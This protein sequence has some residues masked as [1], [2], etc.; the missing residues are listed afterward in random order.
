MRKSDQLVDCLKVPK[1]GSKSCLNFYLKRDSAWTVF[2]HFR[3]FHFSFRARCTVSRIYHKLEIC[4]PFF[5][6]FFELFEFADF[7]LPGKAHSR[8]PSEVKNKSKLQ[9]NLADKVTIF[10]LFELRWKSRSE[11]LKIKFFFSFHFNIH[12]K[13]PNSASVRPCAPSQWEIHLPPPFFKNS[14]P[15]V[16]STTK[17]CSARFFFFNFVVFSLG[18]EKI[19]DTSAKGAKRFDV[20]GRNLLPLCAADW[21]DALGLRVC[22]ETERP[23]AAI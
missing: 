13:V 23:S 6:K 14:S 20:V 17:W 4:P 12:P 15:Q 5:R 10:P 11:I 22:H 1:I 16:V 7:E 21:R 8:H 9:F 18:Y 2:P 19:P 3:S